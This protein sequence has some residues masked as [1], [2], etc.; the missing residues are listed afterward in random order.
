MQPVQ[1]IKRVEAIQLIEIR[2]FYLTA[3]FLPLT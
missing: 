1:L 2:Q 3:E